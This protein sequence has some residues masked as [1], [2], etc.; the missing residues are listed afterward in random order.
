[1][2]IKIFKDIMGANS[3]LAEEN[4]SL[5]RERKITAVN[6]M[7]SPGAGKTSIILKVI[8]MLGKETGAGVIEGDIAS[9]IDAEK[10]ENLGIPVVQI[11][12]GGGCH[13]DA[14]MIKVVMEDFKL[15]DGSILFIENVG[16]LVCPSA[17]DLGENL[18]L[19]VASVPE[20]HDKPYKYTSMFEAADAIIL[21]KI[22]LAPYID[23]DRDSFYKGVRALK[24][25]VPVFE[26]S[27]TTGEGLDE[28]TRWLKGISHE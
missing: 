11:N 8:E 9:S 18:K 25:N 10:M 22:D 7:A 5:F 2:E 21:N 27:C 20:G 28:F 16:N 17:F 13:L 12:T 26:I 1:M 4:R 24:E 23:F 14:N 6:V 19:V 15:K 3:Q